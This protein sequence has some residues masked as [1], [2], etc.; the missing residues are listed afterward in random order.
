MK[1]VLASW[2]SGKTVRGH[3]ELSHHEEHTSALVALHKDGYAVTDHIGVYPDGSHALGVVGIL[4]NGPGPKA[5]HP[6]RHGRAPHRR[7]R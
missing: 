7:R 1:R 6:R 4:K 2:S 5:A 3:S